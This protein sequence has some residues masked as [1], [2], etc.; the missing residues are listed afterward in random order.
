MG[1]QSQE[2]NQKEKIRAFIGFFLP[3]EIKKVVLEIQRRIPSF[4]GKLVEENNLH[5]TLKFLGELSQEELNEIKKVLKRVHFRKIECSID[6]LG[7]F[8][9]NF[10]RIIWLYL[11]NSEDLQKEVDEALK[12]LFKTEN[13]FMSHLTIARIKSIRDKKEF[14]DQLK[15]IN[16]DKPNFFIEEMCLI[17]SELKAEGPEYEILDKYL[18]S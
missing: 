12:D 13:R 2:S 14:I 15:I 7:F 4:K 16:F 1:E 5:L 10:V 11:K 3:D 18:L 9:E 8:S 17:K 6:S